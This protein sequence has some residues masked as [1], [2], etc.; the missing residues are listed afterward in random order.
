VILHDISPARVADDCDWSDLTDSVQTGPAY[1]STEHVDA[2]VVPFDT[3]PTPAEAKAVRRRLMTADAA[4]EARVY[5]LIAAV[6]DNQT[7]TY[8]RLILQSELARYGE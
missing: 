5:D 4:E 6:A 8:A 2:L 3:E 1:W 7:P